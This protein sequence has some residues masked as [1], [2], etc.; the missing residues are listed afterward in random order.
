VPTIA[1][2]EIVP[3]IYRLPKVALN[4]LGCYLFAGPYGVQSLR[5]SVCR[6]LDFRKSFDLLIAPKQACDQCFTAS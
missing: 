5:P 3:L 4:A 2:L 6:R 1:K